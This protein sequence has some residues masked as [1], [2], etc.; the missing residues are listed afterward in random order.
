MNYIILSVVVFCIGIFG[1]LTRRNLIVILM[2]I[3][4]MLSA[5]NIA[6]VSFSRMVGNLDGHAVV[7]LIFI[8][9]ACEAAVG[10][11]IIV[12]AWRLLGT[13]DIGRWREL[14]K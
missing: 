8:I 5:A 12:S 1:V 13:V 4:L 6:F 2:S 10:L 9:A 11:A 7:L 14:K 3:E